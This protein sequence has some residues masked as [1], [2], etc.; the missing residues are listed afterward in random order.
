MNNM[1][2][3]AIKFNQSLEEWNVENVTNYRNMF[4]GTAITEYN[5]A[6]MKVGNAGWA[7]KD[8]VELG[9]PFL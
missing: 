8:E 1:F 3:L 4:K 5:W 7:A 6:I 2:E 9:L